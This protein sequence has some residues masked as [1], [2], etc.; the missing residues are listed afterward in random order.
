MEHRVQELGAITP[1]HTQMGISA[2]EKKKERESVL[3]FSLCIQALNELE[4]AH[5]HWEKYI[6]SL[7]FSFFVASFLSSFHTFI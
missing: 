2:Q 7:F 4:E 5:N 1:R 3:S 6:L